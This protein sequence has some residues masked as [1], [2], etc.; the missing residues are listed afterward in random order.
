MTRNM[1]SLKI[2]S[3]F[4]QLFTKILKI[5]F[6][7]FSVFDASNPFELVKEIIFKSTSRQNKICK[8]ESTTRTQALPAVMYVGLGD[9][10]I[11]LQQTPQTIKH[12]TVAGT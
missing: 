6:S 2:F 12:T 10:Q 3:N 8:V 4:L 7:V 1:L 5:S 9:R 11:L